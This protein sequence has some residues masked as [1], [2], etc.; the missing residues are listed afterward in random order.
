MDEIVIPAG[1]RSP[2]IHIQLN[3]VYALSHYL[4]REAEAPLVTVKPATAE[5]TATFRRAFQPSAVPGLVTF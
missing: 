4:R 3:P 5:A 1:E 2:A